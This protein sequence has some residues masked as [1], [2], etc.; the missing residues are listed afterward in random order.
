MYLHKCGLALFALGCALILGGCEEFDMVHSPG[1]TYRISARVDAELVDNCGIVGASSHVRPYFINSV[2][3]DPDVAG[4]SVFLRSPGGDAVS[5]KVRYSLGV[6]SRR[7][8]LTETGSTLDAPEETGGEDDGKENAGSADQSGEF[9]PPRVSPLRD[10]LADA[11]ARM[12][13]AYLDKPQSEDA[14]DTILYVNLLNNELPPFLLPEDLEIGQYSLVFQLMGEREIL[15]QVEKPLYYLGDAEFAQ[16]DVQTYLP[17]LSGGAHIV[18]PG[19][20]IL[21]ETRVAAD[22]RL[23]P[24]VIWY[25]GK[26]RIGEGMLIGG[27]SHL[28]WA[29]PTQTGFHAIRAEVFPFRPQGNA[30]EIPA[31]KV[32]ELSLPVSPRQGGKGYFKDDADTRIRWYQFSGTLE[33][34]KAPGDTSRQ[35]QTQNGAFP[36]WLPQGGIYGLALE[37]GDVYHLPQQNFDLPEGFVGRGRF[38]LRFA[39][40]AEGLIFSGTFR[41]GSSQSDA[42]TLELTYIR[43]ELVLS[44]TAA[45]ERREDRM[46]VFNAETD[47]FITTVINFQ[48]AEG[49]FYAGLG[50]DAVFSPEQGIALTQP[51]SGKGSFQLGTDKSFKTEVK[52]SASITGGGGFANM[53]F[54]ILGSSNTDIPK[55]GPL[56]IID[57]LALDYTLEE[58]AKTAPEAEP[59]TTGPA[60]DAP[61]EQTLAL[62]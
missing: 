33:D 7:D 21:L 9:P 4:L 52:N 5:K 25:N 54:S 47:G 12:A 8:E 56:A 24:Y 39:P 46:P 28:M 3:N 43:D 13:R 16:E 45:E 35:I 29:A 11:P 60:E 27:S 36:R 6:P 1:E 20:M 14:G 10:S 23:A 44:F 32:K 15:H 42:A 2:S 41:Q 53:N 18:S 55:A 61:E 58:N 37:A 49:H 17:G 62:P 59:E 19:T 30:R 57:E 48:L 26:K 31:G 38:M 51:L 50:P 22:K 34:A 40:L